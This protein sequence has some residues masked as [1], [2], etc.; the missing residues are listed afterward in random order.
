[1]KPGRAGRN[2]PALLVVATGAGYRCRVR[3]S[4]RVH[5]LAVYRP[6]RA[7]GCTHQRPS[8]DCCTYL[9]MVSCTHVRVRPRPIR[10]EGIDSRR[11]SS[12]AGLRRY[13]R[14]SPASRLPRSGSGQ[15][16]GDPLSAGSTAQARRR[17]DGL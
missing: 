5:G 8:P 14:H 11:P 13:R 3:G 4:Q 6:H 17:T 1:M 9:R 12:Q 2:R 16:G 7:E 15:H 10:P